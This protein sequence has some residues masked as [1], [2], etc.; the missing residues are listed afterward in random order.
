MS[1]LLDSPAVMA[2]SAALMTNRNSPSVKMMSGR[3]NSRRMG[4]MIRFT[5][6]KMNATQTKVKN[7]P[8]TL[9]SLSRA[10]P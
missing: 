2:S 3:L 5:T 1:S 6:E 7:P 8:C 10:S 4:P 9:R